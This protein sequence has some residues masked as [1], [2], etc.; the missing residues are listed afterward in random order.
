MKKIDLHN[1]SNYSDGESSFQELLDL[2]IEKKISFFSITDHNYISPEQDKFRALAEKKGIFFIQG[3][4]VSCI[5]KET[6]QSLHILGYSNSFKIEKINEALDHIIQGYNNRAKKIIGKLNK[7]YGADFNFEKIKN[8]TLAVYVS[9]NHLIKKLSE[10]LGNKLSQKELL[11]EVFIEEGNSWMPDSFEAIKIIHKYGGIA[12]LAHPGN[13]IK[14]D[15]FEELI[16]KLVKNGLKG[17]EVYYPKHNEVVVEIL[18]NTSNKFNLIQT[19]GSDWHGQS[20]SKKEIGIDAPDEI[21]SK[22]QE[23]F[24]K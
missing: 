18:K 9:R 20:F 1:H 23:I 3:I 12:V 10:F 13:I 8:E 19:G 16:A 11:Q 5:D 6:G 15:R 17:I 14:K 2:A 24:K 4:E 21:Y 7:K 22:L